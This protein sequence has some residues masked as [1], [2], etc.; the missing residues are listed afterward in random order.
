MKK[1][2]LKVG[3]YFLIL[4][5][6]ITGAIYYAKSKSPRDLFFVS[7]S[8]TLNL[9]AGFVK[10]NFDKFKNSRIYVIGSSM[11]LNNIDAIM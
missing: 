1:F 10:R 9:K 4:A 2:L 3:L 11:S 6:L 8:V 7:N 5:V